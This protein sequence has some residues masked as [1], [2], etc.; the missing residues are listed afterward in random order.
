M[1]HF[2]AALAA[3]LILIPSVH[4]Q[5]GADSDSDVNYDAFS[6]RNIGPAF[7]SGRIA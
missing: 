5:E 7:T 2:L 6:L 1:K 3:A 4:A